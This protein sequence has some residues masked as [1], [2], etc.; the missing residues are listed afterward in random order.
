MQ[1]GERKSSRVVCVKITWRWCTQMGRQ[2][3]DWHSQV[4]S[5]ALQVHGS[6]CGWFV[7]LSGVVPWHRLQAEYHGCLDWLRGLVHAVWCSWTMPWCS[8]PSLFKAVMRRWLHTTARAVE[9]AMLWDWPF[10]GFSLERPYILYAL[11]LPWNPNKSWE[12]W[13]QNNCCDTMP[14]W[15]G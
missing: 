13:G 5:D 8:S 12:L 14:R 6:C 4:S 2:P 15:L 11:F 10:S 7:L 1:S 9:P 3:G